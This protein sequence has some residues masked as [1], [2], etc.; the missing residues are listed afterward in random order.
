MSL[1]KTSRCRFFTPQGKPTRPYCNKGDHCRSAGSHSPHGCHIDAPSELSYLHPNDANWRSA[2]RYKPSGPTLSAPFSA[3]KA[4]R[5]RTRTSS[6]TPLRPVRHS[7]PL[8]SQ[9]DLFKLN[10]DDDFSQV[11]TPRSGNGYDADGYGERTRHPKHF[12]RFLERSD[13]R[14]GK[15]PERRFVSGSS[16]YGK[17]STSR[18]DL[19]SSNRNFSSNEAKYDKDRKW[20][21]IQPAECDRT[22]DEIISR[23]R[24]V[25]SKGTAD[26]AKTVD[27]PRRV[28]DTPDQRRPAEK[29][30]EL[31]KNLANISNQ[32]VQD[33]AAYNSEEQKLK[34]YRELSSTL[35]EIST[36]AAKAV[37]PTLAGVIASRAKCK[38]RV[39]NGL[40]T[41]GYLWEDIFDVFV[42]S[43]VGTIDGRLQD[44]LISLKREG[45]NAVSKVLASGSR[46]LKR[47]VGVSDSLSPYGQGR[48]GQSDTLKEATHTSS[49]DYDDSEEVG[50][51][52]SHKR[53]RLASMSLVS[54]QDEEE[55]RLKIEDVDASVLAMLE[56]MKMKMD[57]QAKTVE[58]LTQENNKACFLHFMILKTSLSNSPN[59]AQSGSSPSHLNSSF[60][61]SCASNPDHDLEQSLQDIEVDGN[62]SLGAVEDIL[63]DDQLAESE[64][65]IDCQ[66][67]RLSLTPQ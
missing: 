6:S 10:A 33:T 27:V 63:L 35:S 2:D 28:E 20:S 49:E 48:R 31:F 57:R 40:K 12:E 47:K 3:P 37:A 58:T 50:D 67:K 16:S 38:E 51:S 13:S 14:H 24:E 4:S 66:G 7:S 62:E 8:V 46:S 18:F 19:K 26:N 9:S 53:R 56:D 17:P 45:E 30:V 11:R 41:L 42:Q 39:D 25:S 60:F 52:K 65:A 15:K 29:V 43:V 64:S 1:Y 23:T 34:N 32:A 61:F 22:F 44:A 59:L 5:M 54:H 36:S 55:V 21:K